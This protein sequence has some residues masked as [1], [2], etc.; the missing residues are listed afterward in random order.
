L[1]ELHIPKYK[2]STLD[3]CVARVGDL[4]TIKGGSTVS[5]GCTLVDSQIF[6]FAQITHFKL[7]SF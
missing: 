5:P 4:V 2:N 3:P 6:K 7:F 1:V